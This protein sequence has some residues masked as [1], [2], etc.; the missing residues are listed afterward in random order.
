[1]GYGGGGHLEE[2][3][4]GVPRTLRKHFLKKVKF[5]CKTSR[6]VTQEEDKQKLCKS[7]LRDR[8]STHTILAAV[9]VLLP[10]VSA[11]SAKSLDYSSSS[12]PSSKLGKNISICLIASRLC[13]TCSA[14]HTAKTQHNYYGGEHREIEE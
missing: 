3:G 6:M 11:I 12:F 14:R 5:V 10:T 9:S 1:M 8:H 7:A 4:P 2:S 13:Q